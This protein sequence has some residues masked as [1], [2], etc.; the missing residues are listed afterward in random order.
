[1]QYE[2]SPMASIRFSSYDK[3]SSKTQENKFTRADSYEYQ[4]IKVFDSHLRVCNCTKLD[5]IKFA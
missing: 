3:M 1:M 2:L 4:K 5:H